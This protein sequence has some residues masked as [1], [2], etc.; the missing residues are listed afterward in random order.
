MKIQNLNKSRKTN[1]KIKKIS[2]MRIIIMFLFFMLV[3]LMLFKNNKGIKNAL[4]FIKRG[5][6][7]EQV[8]TGKELQIG[9]TVYYNHK[10]A[11]NSS[12]SSKQS[13]TI[14]KG[15][16]K[17]PGYGIKL[18]TV[19]RWN[20]YE[21]KREASGY[22]LELDYDNSGGAYSINPIQTQSN[23]RPGETYANYFEGTSAPTNYSFDS[24]TGKITLSNVRSLSEGDIFYQAFFNRMH[25]CK[26]LSV[27]RGGGSQYSG[28][29]GRNR[30]Y[31]D[32]TLKYVVKEVNGRDVKGAF[33]GVVESENENEYPKNGRKYK[34]NGIFLGP[35]YEYIGT[36]EKE[37]EAGQTFYASDYDLTWS[38]WDKKLDGTVMLVPNNPIGNF[39]T[40]GSVGYTWWEHNAHKI[41]SIFGYGEGADTSATQGFQYKVGSGIENAPDMNGTDKG[42]WKIGS[43]GVNV[44]GSRSLTLKEAEAKL[45][46]DD[47]KIANGSYSIK[48]NKNQNYG[49]PYYGNTINTKM[50]Y[51]VQRDIESSTQKWADTEKRKANNNN[52]VMKNKT[53]F[54]NKSDIKNIPNTNIKHKEMLFMNVKDPAYRP[55]RRS[56]HES[57]ISERVARKIGLA[58]NAIDVRNSGANVKF[59]VAHIN[60]TS[61]GTTENCFVE[62]NGTTFKENDLVLSLK[63]IVFLKASNKYVAALGEANAWDIVNK[64]NKK[65]ELQNFQKLD[66]TPKVN[67]VQNG[68]KIALKKVNN[69]YEVNLE[70]NLGQE[71]SGKGNNASYSV[72]NNKYT[73]EVDNL[74]QGYTFEIS[75]KTGKQIDLK[76]KT[77]YKLMF[78]KDGQLIEEKGSSFS[79]LNIGDVVYYD[80]KVAID[81]N[82]E[83]KQT[84]NIGRGSA[85]EPGSG[86]TGTQTF[87]A[88]DISTTWWVWDKKENGQTVI[89]SDV[90]PVPERYGAIGYIWQEHVLNQI[91]STFGYGPGA[92]TKQVFEYKVGSK[93]ENA[94]DTEIWKTGT[95]GISKSG[96][97]ALNSKDIEEKIQTPGK[98]IGKYTGSGYTHMIFPQRKTTSLTNQEWNDENLAIGYRNYVSYDSRLFTCNKSNVPEGEYKKL[99]FDVVKGKEYVLN[100]SGFSY[101]YRS[102]DPTYNTRAKYESRFFSGSVDSN[103][104]NLSERELYGY[105]FYPNLG[106]DIMSTGKEE[107]MAL[108]AGNKVQIRS[109]QLMGKSPDRGKDEHFLETDN[110]GIRV[111]VY[112][113]ND[114]RYDKPTEGSNSWDVITPE[115]EAVKVEVQNFQNLEFEPIINLV[116]GGNKYKLTKEEQKYV[117]DFDLKDT[118]NKYTVEVENLPQGYTFEIEGITGKEVDIKENVKYT[119]VFK[120]NGELLNTRVVNSTELSIG[121]IVY[122]DHKRAED[123]NNQNKLSV[124]IPNGS[125]ENPGT[126][127]GEDQT[128]TSE[129]QSTVWRVFDIDKN[130]KAVTLMSENVKG[131][132]RRGAIGYIW[133]EHNM[134]KAASTFGYGFGA[135]TSKTFTYSVGSGVENSSDNTIW[136]TGKNGINQSATRA[137]TLEDLENKLGLDDE[138]IKTGYKGIVS[139]KYKEIFTLKAYYPQRKVKGQE[140]TQKWYDESEG[141]ADEKDIK[142]KMGAYKWDFANIPD[143]VYKDMIW[144][145]HKY[146]VLA[147]R[148]IYPTS[149]RIYFNHANVHTDSLYAYWDHFVLNSGSIWFNKISEADQRLITYLRPD[150]KYYRAVGESNAWDIGS[151]TNKYVKINV[152]NNTKN[153]VDLK[154]EIKPIKNTEGKIKTD[155]LKVSTNNVGSKQYTY[156]V[157]KGNKRTGTGDKATFVPL[158]NKYNV[159]ISGLPMGY[160]YSIDGKENVDL[161]LDKSLEYNIVIYDKYNLNIKDLNVRKGATVDIKEAIENL[162]STAKV[163]IKTGDLNTNNVGTKNL[164]LKITLDGKEYEETIK[165]NVL[166]NIKVLTTYMGRITRKPITNIQPHYIKEGT[167]PK[168][169][170]PIK[171]DAN[172]RYEEILKEYGKYNI[173]FMVESSSGWHLDTKPSGYLDTKQYSVEYVGNPN[174]DEYIVLK[175]DG[176][177][178]PGSRKYLYKNGEKVLG[179]TVD[180]EVKLIKIMPLPFTG[181]KALIKNTAFVM[182][183]CIL[184]GIVIRFRRKIILIFKKYNLMK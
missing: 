32:I 6:K 64:E 79:D 139:E 161:D 35:W 102:Y 80:H 156:I 49:T 68:K 89:I 152:K 170:L 162:P 43:N 20:S 123:P 130:T 112:L 96:A 34:S 4:N 142:V 154:L 128:Y 107:M 110:R 133:E 73:V 148:T 50:S 60:D 176:V 94:E 61:I 74:P 13:V 124:S 31:Y 99:I 67:L 153:N 98:T 95:N 147:T 172:S 15:T 118:S 42:N 51:V 136:Q 137:L 105:N 164:V 2:S 87:S 114:L 184:V 78:K 144:K 120:K 117:K 11:E 22:E 143:S 103:G 171:E 93:S 47:T 125:A 116:Q 108:S 83:A 40:G 52:Y 10:I 81:K 90:I 17:D 54:W 29:S 160:A 88:K 85:S 168:A 14:N 165:L 100:N 36:R 167:I 155:N 76:E 23:P 57:S 69:T 39:E 174:K 101:K 145:N 33:S 21:N 169:L 12:N 86:K 82:N 3:F 109:N 7:S 157:K 59:N 72:P 56:G 70:L 92:D 8:V 150:L 9:D 30:V 140:A 46:I 132:N 119:L 5:F 63:P 1:R 111:L 134:H 97:R 16:T 106:M 121:D 91:A 66:F 173:K 25:K 27:E 58:T 149:N 166:D 48:N 75:G 159:N 18:Q 163:D 28:S 37:S 175:N 115:V 129:N 127:I 44:S 45:G 113:N 146:Y 183:M 135:D 158:E 177:E 77:L 71:R 55:L 126:G 180:V 62:S 182:G 24:R 41:S 19:Y 131:F 181:S 138:R 179:D 104:I 151:D 122:Y 53:Y 84:V 65:I 26:V 38:V 178:V 141:R